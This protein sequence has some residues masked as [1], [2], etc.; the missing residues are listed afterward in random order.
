[1]KDI[2]TLI[3]LKSENP[4]LIK[5]FCYINNVRSKYFTVFILLLALFIS[6]YDILFL[7]K[8]GP[9]QFF[10]INFKV[11]LVLMVSS[12]IFTIYIFF[13]Q[14]KSSKE[15]TNHHKFIHGLIS[16]FFICWSAIK[17]ALYLNQGSLHVY[18]LIAS[19]FII[20]ILY[21][22]PFYTYLLQL[23]FAFVLFTI[24]L[25]YIH[26]ELD[27]VLYYLFITLVFS[28]IAF[29]GRNYV[30]NLHT[31]LFLKDIEI[32]ILKNSKKGKEKD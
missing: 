26:T 32:E 18:L 20:S 23:F 22:F 28:F 9:F 3:N 12:F 11:D 21:V 10:L 16:L 24:S 19:I 4:E 8:T 25:F 6:S 7:Q 31:K 1:M 29:I 2:Y 17:T 14:V 15:V 13:N 30:F 27:Q 5:K